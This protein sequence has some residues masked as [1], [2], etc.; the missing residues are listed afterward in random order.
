MAIGISPSR[1][2]RL[3]PDNAGADTGPDASPSSARARAG[4]IC[5]SGMVWDGMGW[6]GL[7]RVGAG[8]GVSGPHFK[9]WPTF[10]GPRATE[11]AS[12]P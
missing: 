1:W 12:F 7:V 10:Q 3:A 9:S 2:A 11:T 6:C 5:F 4:L 8:F